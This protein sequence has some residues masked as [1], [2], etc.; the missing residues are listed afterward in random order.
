MMVNHQPEKDGHVF[1][2]QPH[3]ASLRTGGTWSWCFAASYC[4]LHA[5]QGD[6]VRGKIQLVWGRNF[7]KAT[8]EV[9]QKNCQSLVKIPV[10]ES[11]AN[12]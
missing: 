2:T 5:H 7:S 9:E 3:Y 1:L 12:F 11:L 10:I 8:F 4:E 6:Q